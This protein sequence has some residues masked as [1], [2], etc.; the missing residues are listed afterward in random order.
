MDFSSGTGRL[1]D[2][3]EAKQEYTKP[4]VLRWNGGHLTNRN[5]NWKFIFR[6]EQYEQCPIEAFA[7]GAHLTQKYYHENI[8][9]TEA[10][11]KLQ[12]AATNG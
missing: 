6:F 4:R 8:S 10:E 1:L 12:A 9:R 2:V 5:E 7:N 11:A 3:R